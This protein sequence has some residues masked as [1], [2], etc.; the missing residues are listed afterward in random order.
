VVLELSASIIVEEQLLALLDVPQ[1][2]KDDALLLTHRNSLRCNI[3][4]LAPRSV[5]DEAG[6]IAEHTRVQIV[7]LA[8]LEG[9]AKVVLHQLLTHS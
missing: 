7:M 2:M 9:V 5:V 8:K 6:L 3:I 1:G 4:I